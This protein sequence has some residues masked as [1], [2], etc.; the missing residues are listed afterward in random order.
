MIFFFWFVFVFVFFN[1]H[2]IRSEH[3]Q[4]YHTIKSQ[5]RI[6]YFTKVAINDLKLIAVQRYLDIND[7]VANEEIFSSIEYDE[8]NP[9][10]SRL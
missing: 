9:V 7:I 10:I 3:D 4:D 5:P 2:K 1:I 8:D 6:N